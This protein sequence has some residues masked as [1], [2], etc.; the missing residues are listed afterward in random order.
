MTFAVHIPE[1]ASAAHLERLLMRWPCSARL[2]HKLAET[3]RLE[4][5]QARTAAL[6]RIRAGIMSADLETL[7]R[8]VAALEQVA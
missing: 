2:K 4:A 5:Q 7:Q 6:K 8:L 3:R 1:H